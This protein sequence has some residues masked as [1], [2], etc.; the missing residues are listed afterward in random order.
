MKTRYYSKYALRVLLVTL[1]D[2]A[3]RVVIKLQQTFT[4]GLT[5]LYLLLL[6]TH[7]AFDS[8]LVKILDENYQ[9]LPTGGQELVLKLKNQSPTQPD[10]EAEANFAKQIFQ[11]K[12]RLS[13]KN[14]YI[15]C[16]IFRPTSNTAERFFS[17]ASEYALSDIR[18]RLLP[19][20][21]ELQ[22]FLK[23][24]KSLWDMNTVKSIVCKGN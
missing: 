13:I 1:C 20:N 6:Y 7:Y 19:T 8:A 11:K 5:G 9:E 16:K 22:L 12:R 17:T 2:L 4:D 3:L 15:D 21:L 14:S 10:E 18:G 23:F 24:N